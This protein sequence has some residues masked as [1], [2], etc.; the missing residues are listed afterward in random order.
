MSSDREAAVNKIIEG[1][2]WN[3]QNIHTH[4]QIIKIHI[5]P[6]ANKHTTTQSVKR[7]AWMFLASQKKW[8]SDNSATKHN[9]ENNKN[10]MMMMMMVMRASKRITI[11]KIMAQKTNFVLSQSLNIKKKTLKIHVQRVIWNV[12]MNENENG[13]MSNMQVVHCGRFVFSF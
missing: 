1:W 4:S 12:V 2:N 10:T 11:Q 9:N 6:K 5:Q 3:A 13:R 8:S 7:F